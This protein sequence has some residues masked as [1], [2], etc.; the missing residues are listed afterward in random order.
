[1]LHW[2]VYS[3]ELAGDITHAGRPLCVLQVTKLEL[4]LL[5]EPYL[6]KHGCLTTDVGWHG[7]TQLHS[8]TYSA[9][10]NEL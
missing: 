6:A 10:V 8:D 9:L 3:S 7:A 2:C 5:L 4:A 1:M